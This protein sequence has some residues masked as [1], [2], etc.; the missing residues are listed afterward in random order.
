M[1]DESTLYKAL[2]GAYDVAREIADLLE[3]EYLNDA[4]DER[5]QEVLS[6]CYSAVD[7]FS[8]LIAKL[9]LEEKCDHDNFDDAA[10]GPAEYAVAAELM[11][12]YADILEGDLT[13]DEMP[14]CVDYRK[15]HTLVG[16]RA[17][18]RY[19]VFKA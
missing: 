19:I 16:L 12:A 13:C 14:S 9:G 7:F 4:L 6:G 3:H 18:Y 1:E 17:V 2:S 15:V 5:K 10:P 11:K 8:N